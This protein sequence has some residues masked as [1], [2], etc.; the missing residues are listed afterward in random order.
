MEEQRIIISFLAADAK[1][2]AL[3]DDVK[4]SLFESIMKEVKRVS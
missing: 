3:S 1:D 4:R 2:K